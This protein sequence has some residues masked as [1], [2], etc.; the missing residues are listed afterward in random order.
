MLKKIYLLLFVL[1]ISN[2]IAQEAEQ[3]KVNFTGY[4]N[5]SA[6]YDSR[7]V[8]AARESHFL[9][10][11]KEKSMNSQKIDLN[12]VENFNMAVIMTRF[13]AKVS[14]PEFMQAK[15]SAFIETEFMGNSENDVNGLRLRHA[16]VTLDWEN[17]SLL[18]GQTW[19]PMFVP[20][21][22][23]LQVGSNGGAPFQPFARN[24]QIRFTQKFNNLK[25]IIALT[26]QRDYTSFGPI[27]ASNEYLRNEILPDF[28]FHVQYIAEKNLFGIGSE[29][30]SLKPATETSTGFVA[31]NRVNGFAL[32]G[33]SKMF[34]DNFSI[35]LQGLYGTNLTDLTMLGGYAVKSV[36]AITGEE[37]FTPVK[38]TSVWIDVS[39]GTQFKLGLFSGYTKNLGTIEK[40]SGKFYS[41]GANIDNIYRIA[42]R[43]E[44]QE[45]KIKVSVESEYTNASYGKPDDFGKVKSSKDVGNLRLNTSVFYFFN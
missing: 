32:Q 3:F 21:S 15:T 8:V 20:E 45:G 39:Y 38:V 43:A 11:P 1:T 37:S 35:S 14:A 29:F 4:V 40:N 2:L 13:G 18:L 16:Y 10:Y 7:R 34:F 36:D 31:D 42:P 41:R 23:P 28:H 19:N 25:F 24:P 30:K 27:G 5:W 12:K 17:S 44:Y 26:T 22:F 33:Y 6:I 9:L